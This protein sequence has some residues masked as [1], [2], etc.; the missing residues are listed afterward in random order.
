MI[1]VLMAGVLPLVFIV[2]CAGNNNSHKVKSVSGGSLDVATI[3]APEDMN[4][5]RHPDIK[6]RE[7]TPMHSGAGMGL[8]VLGA[9]FGGVISSGAFDKDNYK[10]TTIDAMPEPTARYLGPKADMKIQSWLEKNANGYAYTQPLFIA[11]AQWSLVYTDMS[12]NNSNYDLTYRVKF[13]KRPEGGNMFSA[14]IVSECAPTRKTAPLSEWRA[15][16]Y[17]KVT[18]ETQKM[19]DACM[20]ELENQ[21]PRLLKK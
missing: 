21:L 11:A 6:L 7:V 20:L 13:Y 9:A 10:G 1:K 4:D 8:A 16:N 19:M 2:G 18:Q 17:D 15:N 3:F 5:N 12:A 14:F